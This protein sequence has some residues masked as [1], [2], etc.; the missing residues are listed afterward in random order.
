VP[1]PAVDAR[2][3]RPG[4]TSARRGSRDNGTYGSR[5]RGASSSA[6]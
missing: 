3:R 4:R 5:S 1:A 2:L 6:T